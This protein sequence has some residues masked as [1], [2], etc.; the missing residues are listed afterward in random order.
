MRIF[1]AG[2]WQDRDQKIEVR[3]PYDATIV[4]TVPQATATDAEAAITGAVQGAAAMRKLSGYERFQILRKAA[5]LMFARQKELGRLI[6]LEEGKILAEGIFEA[7]RAAETLELS[8][9][10]AKRL[11]GE[12]LPLDGAPGAAGKFGFTVRVPCGVVVAIT[13]FNFPLNLVCHKVGP[14]LAGGNSVILKP[15]SNTPLSALRLVEIL[16]EAG[17][18]PLAINALVGSGSEIGKALCG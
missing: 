4:D 8:A 10:E 13:P 14:A 18:P 17:L 7:S 11:G 6:S 2:Q 16:L 1:F 3:N 5:D 12:V 9:E 15:A